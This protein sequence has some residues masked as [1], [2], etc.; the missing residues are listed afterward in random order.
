[1][2][3]IGQG[4]VTL[5][6]HN[7]EYVVNFPSGFGRSILTVPWVEL[8]GKVSIN[9]PQTGYVSNIEFKCKQFFSSDV[10]KVSKTLISARKAISEQ[11]HRN[12]P[13]P[14]N[15]FRDT[16]ATFHRNIYLIN[17]SVG[18]RSSCTKSKETI[19]ESGGRMER[20]NGGQMD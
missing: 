17:F 2:Y 9:C 14:C 7:E 19:F 16:H 3:N 15:Q 10:N 13:Q 20:Q 5:M 12:S 18:R 11:F 1:M 4:T 8:G 6:D